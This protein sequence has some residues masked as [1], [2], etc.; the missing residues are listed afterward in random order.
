MGTG[1]KKSPAGAGALGVEE[2][3]FHESEIQT[4]TNPGNQRGNPD[5]SSK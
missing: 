1:Q 5:A 3:N 4:S 2:G